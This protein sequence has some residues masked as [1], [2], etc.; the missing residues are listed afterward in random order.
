MNETE[1]QSADPSNLQL[2][3]KSLSTPPMADSGIPE[4]AGKIPN[5]PRIAAGWR[6][7]G[8]AK[9]RVQR[10]VKSLQLVTGLE[11]KTRELTF[12]QIRK[13]SLSL[14]YRAM[15]GESLQKLLPEAFA[16]VREAGR[17]ALNMRHFD[18]QIVGGAAL[19]DGCITEMQ[20]GEGKTLTA[21]LP[22]YLHSLSGKGAHLATVNDYLAHRDAMWMKPIYDLL[23]ISV[24][25]VL[26]ESTP[27]ERRQ[28]YASDITYGT[29]KEFG[30]DFLR[31]RLLL[32]A[33][34]RMQSDFL[35]EGSSERWSS[36]GDEPVQ[37]TMHFALV[38]EADSILIDEA[39]TPLI[40]GSLG[41]E[42]REAVI[43]T[44]RW[45]AEHAPK[46]EAEEHFTIDDDH[47]KIE[48][49][50]RGRALVRSL[51]RAEDMHLVS[52]VDLYEYSERAIKVHR[53]FH[54]D[55]HYV[56]RDDEIVIVDEFTGRLA[57]G[58]KWRDGIHQAIEAKE[59]IEV[60]VPTGQAAR[61]TVQDLFHRY[62]SIAGMTGTASTSAPEL[63]KIYKT[64]VVLVPTNRPPRRQ[65]L[66]DQVYGTMLQKFEAIVTEVRTYHDQGRPVLIGTRSIDKSLILSK[67]L[68]DVGIATDVLN[69]NEVEREAEIVAEAGKRG[70]VTV[71]TN[72]AGRGTDVKLEQA[73]KD[74]GGMHVICTELHDAA[75]IDRQLI[76]RCGRQGDPGSY[77]QYLS[78]DDDILRTGFGNK[79]AEQLALRGKTQP[80]P[81]HSMASLFKKAQRRV[82]RKHFRDR[83]MLLHHEQERTKLQ[84]EIGQDPYLDT[85]E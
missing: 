54:L 85:A 37:R 48:L 21:T 39:R 13:E 50:A 43:A 23:G 5:L 9:M 69:A 19:Y 58:R 61:I 53:D 74:L 16:L 2:S 42:T 29:A 27:D 51:P 76:G 70:R 52:L 20:T 45:A 6:V 24:G 57:E 60:S 75:R 84:R 30:F 31:D 14:R 59:Q 81:F 32:R 41:D 44:F 64:P 49:T 47:R 78:L 77:R 73:V 26:T 33:Q 38:D 25:V 10:W 56:I 79:R 1:A 17:R 63:R 18:V 28:A 83:M 68:R 15:S 40:I 11:R 3:A 55:R 62:Q 7:P 80:G 34:G 82:E 35:G 12:E 8:A 66:P 46:F 67:M 65:R 71:A 36:R 22:L 4:K 72:M